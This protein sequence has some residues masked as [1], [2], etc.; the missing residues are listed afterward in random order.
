VL[1]IPSSTYRC[2]RYFSPFLIW[3]QHHMHCQIED[4]PGRCATRVISASTV[5]YLS[6]VPI[7][8]GK[9]CTQGGVHG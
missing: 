6:A 9:P 4:V 2:S 8:L 5:I 1:I 3:A 7:S